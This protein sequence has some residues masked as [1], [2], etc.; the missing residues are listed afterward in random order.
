MPPEG[1]AGATPERVEPIRALLDG[2]DSSLD[3][4]GR[5]TLEGLHRRLFEPLRRVGDRLSKLRDD[6]LAS[7]S[8]LRAAGRA[9]RVACNDLEDADLPTVLSEELEGHLERILSFAHS[10]PRSLEIAPGGDDAARRIVPARAV[11]RAV[12]RASYPERLLD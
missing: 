9:V 7:G 3:Q 12:L 11:V 1:P 5:E 4:A 8:T 2:L 6:A 10:T